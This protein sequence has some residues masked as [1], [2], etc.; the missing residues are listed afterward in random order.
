M[1]RKEFG[2]RVTEF[3]PNQRYIVETTS[4]SIRPVQRFMFEPTASK[5]YRHPSFDR[6][7]GLP[8]PPVHVI[9]ERG[10][11]T[12]EGYVDTLADRLAA[13]SIARSFGSFEVIDELVTPGGKGKSEK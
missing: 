6:Y 3:V 13:L 4:G 10:R 11:V 2:Q 7:A 8:N 1:G 9:V 5:I 12:L